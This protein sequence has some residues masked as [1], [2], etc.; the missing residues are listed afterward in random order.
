MIEYKCY[1]CLKTFNRK[2]HYDQ[3]LIRKTLCVKNILKCIYCEK[4][5]SRSDSLRRHSNSC[6]EKSETLI[7]NTN[8]VSI[9]TKPFLKENISFSSFFTRSEK[10]S[11]LKERKKAIL[12]IIELINCNDKHPEYQNVCINDMSRGYGTYLD[13]DNKWK[14]KDA[15]ELV[16]DII[17]ERT[18]NLSEILSEYVDDDN[19]VLPIFKN[20]K[21]II[22]LV[23]DMV[24]D[25]DND[26]EVK[27]YIERQVMLTLYNN[28]DAVMKKVKKTESII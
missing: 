13:S 12:K 16:D 4:I 28:R 3:H 7:I 21:K 1:K 23:N 11:I 15:K 25:S 10:N 22:E 9:N 27:K 20:M 2:S 6:K 5:L 14:V 18:N 24:N 17:T 8:H 19:N 26:E